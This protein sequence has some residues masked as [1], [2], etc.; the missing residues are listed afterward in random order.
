MAR[1]I[2]QIVDWDVVK[3]EEYD[4]ILLA[5]KFGTHVA[6]I[7]LHKLKE[8]INEIQDIIHSDLKELKENDNV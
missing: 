4:E 3:Y 6:R 1:H 2:K 5:D 7:S 8:I